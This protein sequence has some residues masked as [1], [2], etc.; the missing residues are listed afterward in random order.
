MLTKKKVLFNQVAYDMLIDKAARCQDSVIRLRTIIDV[1]KKSDMPR[2]VK[3]DVHIILEN[4]LAVEAAAG[5]KWQTQAQAELSRPHNAHELAVREGV[6][7]DSP[8]YHDRLVEI[9]H[10]LI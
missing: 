9:E 8:M 1:V 10:N 2:K 7:V 6:E 3:R 5:V 4:K